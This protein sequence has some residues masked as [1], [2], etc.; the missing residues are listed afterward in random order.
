MKIEIT[1]T[2]KRKVEVDVEF[3]IFRENDLDSVII[4]TR[5]S[6][7]DSGKMIEEEVSISRRNVRAEITINRDYRFDSS[8]T[9]Y[10]LGRGFYQSSEAEFNEAVA[11]ALKLIKEVA[12]EQD[13]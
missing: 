7:L 2:T 12:G 4:Y 10:L 13:S 9:D 6:L 5:I 1:E 11:T 8:S 3:P